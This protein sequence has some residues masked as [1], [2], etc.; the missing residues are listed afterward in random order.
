MEF[1]SEFCFLRNELTAIFGFSIQSSVITEGKFLKKNIFFKMFE[2]LGNFS[3]ISKTKK[4][5]PVIWR[6]WWDISYGGTSSTF[7]G[8]KTTK[9]NSFFL[10]KKT[11]LYKNTCKNSFCF[12]PLNCPKYYRGEHNSPLYYF[13]IVCNTHAKMSYNF[14]MKS[15]KIDISTWKQHSLEPIQSLEK[16]HLILSRGTTPKGETVPHEYLVKWIMTVSDG[17][18]H[19]SG[20]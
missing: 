19:E 1:L 20:R 18:L 9:L 2:P 10:F 13:S 5:P 8:R 4:K 6:T 14:V 15:W 16:C 11:L 12:F 3:Q 17:K 7:R